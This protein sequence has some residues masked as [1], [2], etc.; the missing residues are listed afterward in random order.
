[1]N[2][3]TTALSFVDRLTEL[4]CV[5]IKLVASLVVVLVVDCC[6]VGGRSEMSARDLLD[7]TGCV[8][9]GSLIVTWSLSLKCHTHS[10][11][12]IYSRF[13]I[14]TVADVQTQL[15]NCFDFFKNI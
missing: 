5:G 10:V 11:Y 7:L 15:S 8:V 14:F 13:I 1:V 3:Y 6:V 4:R 12:F 9:A 2:D